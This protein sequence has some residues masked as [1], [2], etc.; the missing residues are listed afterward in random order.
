MDR[1]APLHDQIDIPTLVTH[2][3]DD[4]LIFPKASAGLAVS[5]SVERR[6]YPGYRHEPH[7]EPKAQA[8]AYLGDIADWIDRHLFGGV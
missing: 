5:P 7:N 3:A 8:E 2:G 1:L 4:T 6:L